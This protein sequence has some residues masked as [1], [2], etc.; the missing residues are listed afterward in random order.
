VG[1]QLQS[2]RIGQC[3]RFDPAPRA[4]RTETV[5]SGGKRSGALRFLGVYAYIGF[6][7]FLALA[8]CGILFQ[9]S[10]EKLNIAKKSQKT[11]AELRYLTAFMASSAAAEGNVIRWL[12]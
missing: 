8:R 4:L 2:R 9:E 6:F 10:E 11:K 7:L 3:Q 12:N 1:R 5:G